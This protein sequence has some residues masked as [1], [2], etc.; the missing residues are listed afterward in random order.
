VTASALMIP[1]LVFGGRR[2][3]I[4]RYAFPC[5][6]GI[7]IAIAY[8]LANKGTNPNFKN[9]HR[10]LWQ[11]FATALISL[12]VISCTI[13]SQTQTWDGRE[14]FIIQASHIINEKTHPLVVS[15]KMDDIMPLS[16]RLNSQVKL[17][18]GVKSEIRFLKN[19][20]SDVFVFQPSDTYLL[21]LKETQKL[22]PIYQHFSGNTLWI[23]NK[24]KQKN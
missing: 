3:V 17:M 18:I 19:N 21:K 1:D 6:L 12:G 11:I 15:D 23:I 7:Q 4:D 22:N 14:D 8:L 16:Y 10:K 2:S 13:I 24:N 20:F 5:I 9:F